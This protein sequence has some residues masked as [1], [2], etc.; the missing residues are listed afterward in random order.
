[1]AIP[2]G[3]AW[4]SGLFRALTGS[5]L[6]Q[7]SIILQLGPCLVSVHDLQVEG[8]SVYET[9]GGNHENAQ[10]LVFELEK[11]PVIKGFFTVSSCQLS[12]L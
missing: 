8:F 3:T 4:S 6:G 7:C 5:G 10:K 9:Y 11:D 1:M 12:Y 2:R